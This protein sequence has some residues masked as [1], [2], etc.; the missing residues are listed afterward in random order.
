MDFS[1][2]TNQVKQHNISS[3]WRKIVPANRSSLTEE[4][5]SQDPI[6]RSSSDLHT[7]EGHLISTKKSLQGFDGETGDLVAPCILKKRRLLI[8]GPDQSKYH[9]KRDHNF[10]SLA[11][12][13][14]DLSENFSSQNLRVK[15]EVLVNDEIVTHKEIVAHN[16]HEQKEDVSQSVPRDEQQIKG[17]SFLNQVKYFELFL[18]LSDAPSP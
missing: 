15:G 6:L 12:R 18:I 14:L 7:M 16:I 4:K 2:S 5:L 9:K 1:S 8:T 17:S 3:L 11:K 10:S 13:S